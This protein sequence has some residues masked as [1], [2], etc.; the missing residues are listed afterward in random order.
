M[1][2]A[3]AAASACLALGISLNDIQMGLSA[4]EAVKGRLYTV[5][6]ATGALWIDDTYNANP[7]SMRAAIDVLASIEGERIFVMGDMAELGDNADQQH[8]EIGLYAKSLGIERCLT[9]GQSS[10][11]AAHAFGERGEHFID[12][13]ELAKALSHY[14]AS[15]QTVLLKGSRSSKMEQFLGKSTG[16]RT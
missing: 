10:A 15:G 16:T 14:T 11:A 5:K 1:L 4:V 9:V 13:T 12:A 2:N 6:Q 3:L 7:A 8:A